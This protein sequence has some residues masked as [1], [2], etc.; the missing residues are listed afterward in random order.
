[1]TFNGVPVHRLGT[2][3]L[4][5]CLLGQAGC[6]QRHEPADFV[7]INGPD[8]ESLDPAIITS[9]ADGRIVSALFDGLTRFN[10]VT[11][12]AEPALAKRW[13]ISGDGTVY[14][15]HL[16]DGL[17]WSTG[18]RITAH[19]V[20]Y[21]WRRAINPDTA[22]DYAGMLFYVKNAEA[23]NSGKLTDLSRLG[24]RA[25]DDKTVRVELI[26]PT[27]FFLELCAFWALAVVPEKAITQH[28]D[29]W[30]LRQPLPVSGSHTLEFWH[31]RDRVRLRKNTHYWDADNTRNNV[32]DFLPVE[33]AATAI[34]LYEA[35]QAD[36][37]WDKS[38][39]PTELLDA[40]SQRPDYHK[41]DYLGSYFVRFNTT[42][43]PL[44]DPRVR[45]AMAL[46]IDKAGLVAKYTK[47]GERLA[48]HFVPPGTGNYSSPEGP[49][50][51]PVL[52]KRLLAEAGFPEGKGFPTD[53][54]YLFNSN[55]RN[56]NIAVELQ[57]MWHETLG[58]QVKL[59]QAE[60]KVYLAAQSALDYHVTR[61]SWIGDYND[62]N[63]FLDMFM[64][65]NGNNRTG[66]SSDEYDRLI[67]LANATTDPAKRNELF[68]SAET[69]L[70]ADELPI[71]PLYF[72][73]GINIYHPDRIGGIH[74]NILDI[75][76]IS[77]IYTKEHPSAAKK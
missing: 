48:N 18:G 41:F 57:R 9:Q 46:A 17:K 26:A 44:D 19:D 42:K 24:V 70:I 77:A 28:G 8:P 37:I 76:P 34:N 56:K 1:M 69:I 55:D 5:L 47:G 53:F 2:L 12:H 3:F 27:P 36:I 32:V 64:T 63:T 49:T 67:R 50:H 30:C 4:C 51:D 6:F 25:I 66:W 40:L 10:A 75:H 71:F 52:A 58:I 68:R 22:S 35:G 72:Y 21:S 33:A 73:V 59:R 20:V 62:P 74:P 39:V 29:Q 11:A 45:K 13:E 65:Q 60:N 15:F 61:S 23:I 54:E 43:K 16:R 38:L 14:T 31:V 7:V